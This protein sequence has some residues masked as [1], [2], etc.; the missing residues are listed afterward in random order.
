MRRLI[1]SLALLALPLLGGTPASACP[2]PPP[3]EPGPATC[4]QGTL[5]SVRVGDHTVS[6]PDPRIRLYCS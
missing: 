6:V 1:P 3:D 5:Y 4:C 2:P